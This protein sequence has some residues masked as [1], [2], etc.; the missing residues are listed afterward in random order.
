MNQVDPGMHL[1]Q[2]AASFEFGDVARDHRRVEASENRLLR[3]ALEQEA[4]VVLL[5]AFPKRSDTLIEEPRVRR[6]SLAENQSLIT[7][8]AGK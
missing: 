8:T 7:G 6:L 3:L 2:F 5:I 4:E 1:E